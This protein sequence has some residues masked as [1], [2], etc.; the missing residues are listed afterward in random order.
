MS[1]VSA[2]DVGTYYYSLT[3]TLNLNLA[4]N[5]VAF[6]LDMSTTAKPVAVV[7]PTLVAPVFLTP[8]QGIFTSA[9]VPVT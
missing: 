1:T 6:K 3:G 7:A 9:N 2:A 8:L 4:A 5:T